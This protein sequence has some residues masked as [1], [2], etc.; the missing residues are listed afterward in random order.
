MSATT[1]PIGSVA[2]LS[3]YQKLNSVWHTRAL[4]LFMFIVLAHWAEHLFYN[5]VVFIPMVFGMYY[6]LFP[7]Q[8]EE[9]A[10]C[11]CSLAFRP[12]TVSVVCK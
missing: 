2:D 7:R 6:H 5:A 12:V 9:S 11:N 1:A 4:N 3:L 10:T 8:R